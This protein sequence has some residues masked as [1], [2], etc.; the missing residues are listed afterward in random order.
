MGQSVLPGDHDAAVLPAGVGF[1][2]EF[3]HAAHGRPGR[4]GAN[5]G[6]LITLT[7]GPAA[8]PGC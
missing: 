3:G 4:A 5:L 7:A 6:N 1:G 8:G 2:Q